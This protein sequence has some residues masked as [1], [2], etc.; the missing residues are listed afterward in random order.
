MGPILHQDACCLNNAGSF[1]TNSTGAMGLL[2]VRN[3]NRTRD[4]AEMNG[5]N[6]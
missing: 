6:N 2:S 5:Q 3:A 1:W 4:L